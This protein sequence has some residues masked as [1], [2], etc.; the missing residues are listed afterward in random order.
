MMKIRIEK[1]IAS[2]YP[3]TRA[4]IKDLIKKGLIKVNNE[5]IKKPINIDTEKDLVYFDNELIKYKEFYYYM[6]NK[7]AGYICANYD[8][9]E[10]TIFDIL[11]L[12]NRQ[13]FA[14]GRLDKDTEG[15]L[16]IS[17]DG[18]LGHYLLSPKHKVAKKYY[19]KVNK[20]F[21]ENI[22]TYTKPIKIG[23]DEFIKDYQFEFI[24][25]FSAYLTIYEGKFHQVKRML[26]FFNYEVIYLKR[27]SFGNLVLDKKLK[28]GEIRELNQDE[29]EIL[30]SREN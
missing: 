24:D 21:T 1:V 19:L 5:I 26:E 2:L 16:I 9:Y 18:K 10:S 30:K 15:L 14:Y 8:K 25:D 23:E 11:D 3:Y 7:P 20:E 29:I 4:E 6:F 28:L 27:L 13:Y 17:N 22:K 12:D